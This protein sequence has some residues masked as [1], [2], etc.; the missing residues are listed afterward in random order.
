MDLEESDDCSKD[1][2]LVLDG[3]NDQA[4][5]INK[6][7]GRVSPSAITSQGSALFV[8]FVSD[9]SLVAS[10]FRATYSKSSS[11]TSPI[12]ILDV[13]FN[14]QFYLHLKIYWNK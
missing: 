8:Q 14:H 5:L 4:P 3:D 1:Y 10:G 13:C 7:C 11:G 12:F 9:N 6:L 2:V